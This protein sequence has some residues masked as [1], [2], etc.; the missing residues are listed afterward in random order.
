MFVRATK[1]VI[2]GLLSLLFL[3]TMACKEA[4]EENAV[5][6][7]TSDEAYFKEP[8][9]QR[10][11]IQPEGNKFGIALY[12]TALNQ[13]LMVN[14]E[15]ECDVDGVFHVPPYVIFDKGQNGAYI[16]I[17]YDPSHVEFD[18]IYTLKVWVAN[19]SLKSATRPSSY[20]FELVMPSWTEWGEGQLRDDLVGGF[21]GKN[22]QWNVTIQKS[23]LKQGLY[24]LL[25]PYG[26]SFSPYADHYHDEGLNTSMV[27]DASDPDFVYF[28]AFNSGVTLNASDGEL[29][30]I[31]MVDYEMQYN[32]VELNTLKTTHPE[33]FGQLKNGLISFDMPY[34]CLAQLSAQGDSFFYRA[35]QKGLLCIALPGNEIKDYRLAFSYQGQKTDAYGND[36]IIGNLTLGSNIE[37]AKYR[38]TN[39][40]KGAEQMVEDIGNGTIGAYEQSTGGTIQ[41]P[42]DTTGTYYVVVVGFA[43]NQVV[44]TNITS[45]DFKS[46]KDILEEWKEVATGTYRYGV[47]ALTTRGRSPY[48]G[49]TKSTLYVSVSDSTRYRIMPWAS[50]KSEGLIFT[51]NHT[52]NI[53]TANS[54]FTGENFIE[55]GDEDYGP[56]LFSD[57]VSYNPDRYSAQSSQYDPTTDTFEFRCCY[58]FEGGWLGAI[59]ETFTIQKP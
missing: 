22:A 42:A 54:V 59:L 23:N 14:L 11:E 28:K 58:H 43:N 44:A 49:S 3:L 52:T 48:S 51:W 45:V 39:S 15:S 29:S 20:T 18:R 33:Y 47:Q 27:I 46:S 30:F 2:G 1:I 6:S 12:H 50:S 37:K 25:T 57:L 35:N 5:V 38:M 4:G 41:L 26:C 13:S 21:D 16:W 17:S 32:G 56:L 36:F 34:S 10:Y 8:L 9:Q 55:N 24:R 53:L 40:A 31:S 7:T 19:D